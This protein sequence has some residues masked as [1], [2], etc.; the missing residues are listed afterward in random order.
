MKGTAHVLFGAD[1]SIDREQ[2]EHNAD[3]RNIVMHALPTRQ[4]TLLARHVIK[5]GT[6]AELLGA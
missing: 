4:H 2:G 1:H 5:S 6:L 3:L